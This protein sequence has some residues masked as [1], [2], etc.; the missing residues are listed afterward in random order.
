M[1]KGKLDFVGEDVGD[2]SLVVGAI[3]ALHLHQQLVVHAADN[4]LLQPAN[5]SVQQSLGYSIFHFLVFS[6]HCST[7]KSQEPYSSFYRSETAI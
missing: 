7:G 6:S 5:V 1:F 2:E 3:L 4:L